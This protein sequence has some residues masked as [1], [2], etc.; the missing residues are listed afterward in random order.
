MPDGDD[1]TVP[2]PLPPGLTVRAYRFK[3]NVAV[4]DF[5]ASMVTTQAPAPVQAPAQD[6]KLDPVAAEGVS[7]TSVPWS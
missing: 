6:V 5:A 4:T 3:V 2:L 1:V 7:V